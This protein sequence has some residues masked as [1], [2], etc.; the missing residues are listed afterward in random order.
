MAA[1]A[2]THVITQRERWI[3]NYYYCYSS[4]FS[5]LFTFIDESIYN[6]YAFKCGIYYNSS[7]LDIGSPLSRLLYCGLLSDWPHFFQ[8]HIHD[9][10]WHDFLYSFSLYMAGHDAF[11]SF[12][13]LSI[14]C[15]HNNIYQMVPYN[16]SVSRGPFHTN[17]QHNSDLLYIVGILN[18]GSWMKSRQKFNGY[19]IEKKKKKKKNKKKNA[20]KCKTV[21]FSSEFRFLPFYQ[22]PYT[23]TT[24]AASYIYLDVHIESYICAGQWCG[25]SQTISTPFS[26]FLLRCSWITCEKS[27]TNAEKYQKNKVL[28]SSY[29]SHDGLSPDGFPSLLTPCANEIRARDNRRDI[30]H[31][32]SSLQ[33]AAQ[34]IHPM[35]TLV[36]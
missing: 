4:P 21:P 18:S 27:Q 3:P 22:W 31:S 19:Q 2:F 26:S 35:W 36:L 24:T 34:H 20:A 6:P 32:S 13:E 7:A 23:T 9:M 8:D 5:L 33:Q 12:N 30:F 28:Y 11:L 17:I 15:I 1:S 25:K 29:S 10:M 14:L 16:L